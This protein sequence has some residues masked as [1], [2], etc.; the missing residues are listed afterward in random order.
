[1]STIWGYNEEDGY[2]IYLKDLILEENIRIGKLIVLKKLTKEEKITEYEKGSFSNNGHN[3]KLSTVLGKEWWYCK[4]DCGIQCIKRKDRLIAGGRRGGPDAQADK[5][6]R[7]CGKKECNNANISLHRNN[8]GST[9]HAHITTSYSGNI[10]LDEST[11][12]DNNRSKY[13]TLKCKKCGKPFIS[14]RRAMIQFCEEC[15]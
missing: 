11:D 8:Q 1:M 3:S 2:P 5:G 6:C 10:I 14:T 13:V 15:R 9:T 4:C 12:I 7:S